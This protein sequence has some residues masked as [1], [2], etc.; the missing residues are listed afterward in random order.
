L[1]NWPL[2]LLWA[3]AGGAW[4]VWL[5]YEDRSTTPVIILASL[6]AV[7]TSMTWLD[8]WGHKA[9]GAIW[10][11]AAIGALV[12]RS[13]PLLASLLILVKISLHAHTPLDFSQ[14]DIQ[15]VLGRWLVW[16]VAGSLAGVGWTLIHDPRMTAYIDK[17]GPVEY[18]EITETEKQA[19]TDD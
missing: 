13:V 17:P 1:R 5:G 19:R 16:M 7:A 14:S 9:G 12:G 10:I 18:N 15:Q 4:L 6:I 3:V 2:R 8:R 11:G